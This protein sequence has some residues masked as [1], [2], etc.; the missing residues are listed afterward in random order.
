MRIGVDTR[1]LMG[2]PTGAGRYLAELLGAW[3][4]P[5]SGAAGR[6]E[7]FL[8]GPSALAT[9]T[10]ARVEALRPT[11]CV[12]PGGGGTSW[13]QLRL[14]AAAN[15]HGLDVFFAPAYT[16]PLRL[17][18]PV[19]LTVHDLSFFAHPEWFRW[20]EGLRRRMFTRLAARRAAVVLTDTEFSRAEIQA[21]LGLPAGR[22]RVVALGAGRPACL[23]AAAPSPGSGRPSTRREPLVLHVGS[24]FNRRRVPD[25]ISAFRLVLASVPDARMEIIG[26][27]RTYPHQDLDAL[28]RASGAADRIRVRSYVSDAELA[29][30]FGQ[31]SA[32]AFL[33]EY[34]G[35]GL[36]PLEALASG[37]PPVLLD[38]PVAREV[39]GPAARY[40]PSGDVPAI[41]A[42]LTALLR[43]PGARAAVLHEAAGVLSR[44]SWREAARQTMDALERA[45]R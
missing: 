5:A 10:T 17:A 36:P 42:A 28:C 44:Y 11:A 39:C 24:V 2:R 18:C 13:E 26:E 29:A 6:H 16:A 3:A 8:Y 35:F 41:A 33:S 40:V 38:T 23:E 34:E 12:V 14:P 20:R 15:R 43:D 4:D 37:I 9:A 27:N 7:F 30:A 21:H 1:E 45:G 31:A 22:I 32:F 25:L 19:A